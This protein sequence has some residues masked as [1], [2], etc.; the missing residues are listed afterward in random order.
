[1]EKKAYINRNSRAAL[2]IFRLAV[3]LFL[4]ILFAAPAMAGGAITG[5]FT[6]PLV[7]TDIAVSDIGL[8]AATI[9]WQT[10]GLSD[11]QVEYG[12]TD[13]YGLVAS[14]PTDSTTSQ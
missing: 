4:F 8:N 13:S 3:F 7:V 10:N 11:S 6:V 14:Q 1:M 5:S 12:V 9:T 2:I